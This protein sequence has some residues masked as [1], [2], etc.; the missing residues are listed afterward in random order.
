MEREAC[1]KKRGRMRRRRFIRALPSPLTFKPRGAPMTELE[2]LELKIEELE[3]LR[4]VDLLGF[5]LQKAADSMKVS[6]RTLTRDLK[7]ARK[8]VADILVN[9]KAMV[10]QGGDFELELKE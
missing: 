3:A 2:V 6:R 5:D 10:I 7:S 9:G 1:C 4:L 8:K